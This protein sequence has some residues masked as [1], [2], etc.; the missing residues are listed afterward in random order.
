MIL[1]E[2]VSSVRADLASR[3]RETPPD[4]MSE[5]A[6][7]TPDRNG[8]MRFGTALRHSERRPALI[9][10]VKRASPSKGA[11]RQDLDACAL[12]RTYVDAGAAAISVLTEPSFFRGSLADLAEV[13]R[14]V[15]APTLRKDFLVDAY[16]VHEARIA[17]ASAVLLIARVLGQDLGAMLDAVRA[18]GLDALVEVH[19]EADVGFAL[20]AGAVIIG[21]NNRD[22]ATFDVDLATTERLRKTVPAQVVFVSES[23]ISTADDVRRVRDAGADAIL[24]GESL[25]R[26]VDTR[27]A[28]DALYRHEP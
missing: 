27:A 25:V 5:R 20:N 15:Q 23:G 1:D 26:A 21:C 4:V 22:L 2:I 8:R 12:A 3:M 14:A 16:Q 13:S 18:A 10:E 6:A 24:V 28:I 9:A 17:G 7:R 19:D 11:I